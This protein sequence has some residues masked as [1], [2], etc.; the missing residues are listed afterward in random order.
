MTGQEFLK[1]QDE[2][3]FRPSV[4]DA[5]IEEFVPPKDAFKITKAF[6]PQKNV[7]D[8]ELISLVKAGAFGMTNPVALG[9]DHMKIGLP[10]VFYKEHKAGY[11]RESIVFDEEVLQRVK[12][13]MKPDQ[14]WGE[15]LVGE[16][17]NVLDLRLNT[18]IEYLSAQT[19]YSNGFTIA[20]N[21]VSYTFDPQ[22]PD[23]YYIYVG[24]TGSVPSGYVTTP[25]GTGAANRL[26]NDL[27]NSYPL[28]DIREA[29]DHFAKQ[30]FSTTELW[31][32]RKVAGYLEDNTATNGIRDF[33]I[34][35]PGLAGQMITAEN[36]VLSVSGLKGV[37]PVI[38]DRRY[39]E[40]AGLVAPAAAAA[41][42]LSVTDVGAFAVSDVITLRNPATLAEEDVKIESIASPVLTLADSTPTVNAFNYGDRVTL[43]K[44]YVP[45]NQI[46]FR[47][48]GNDRVSYANWVSTPSLVKAKDFKNPQPGRYTWTTFNDKVPYWVEVGAGI[49]GGPVVHSAGN[50]MVMQVT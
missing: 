48:T 30:G 19:V 37:Q 39:L 28:N 1:I 32:P 29:I 33:I 7:D 11:W 50:W 36:I 14:Y 40:E 15:Q 16:A 17:L 8:D 31:M 42:T 6:M 5:I 45:E 38:D 21:G 41:T 23:K 3:I 26:W 27:T 35:N 47:G 24:A 46:A 44:L 4:M 25:W 12:N 2:K 9:G 13:P 49:N 43:S 22:V 10:T 20:K 34:N 18:L